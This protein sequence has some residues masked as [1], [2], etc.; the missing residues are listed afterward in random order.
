VIF[1]RVRACVFKIVCKVIKP[2]R[3]TI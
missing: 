3:L 2:E 1:K